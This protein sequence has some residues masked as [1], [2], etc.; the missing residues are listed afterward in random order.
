MMRCHHKAFPH[1]WQ[2]HA[3]RKVWERLP[4]HPSFH[5]II[6]HKIAAPSFVLMGDDARELP[7][8]GYTFDRAGLMSAA[9]S[10]LSDD[11]HH[12]TLPPWGLYLFKILTPFPHHLRFCDHVNHYNAM[13][14]MVT[15]NAF[16]S[17]QKESTTPKGVAFP[18]T[19]LPGVASFRRQPQAIESITPMGLHHHQPLITAPQ[20]GDD[21]RHGIYHH[22]TTRSITIPSREVAHRIA[23]HCQAMP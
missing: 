17:T 9:K 16:D 14:R 22:A 10:T 21:A 1:K 20:R 13:P 18:P 7:R 23:I 3:R 8:R 4:R 11:I 19:L 5:R 6:Q 15:C 12:R 2:G